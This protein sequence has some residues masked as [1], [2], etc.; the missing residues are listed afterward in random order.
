MRITMKQLTAKP[1]LLKQANLCLIRKVIKNK[2]TATRAEIASETKISSTTVRSLLNE[3]IEHGEIESI[4]HD[5]SSGGRKA[6]RYAFLPNRYY[7]AAFCISGC[8]IHALLVNIC[9]EIVEITQLETIN[10]D[11]EQVIL[12]FLDKLTAKMEIRAIG[13]GVPGIVEGGGYWKQDPESGVLYKAD[14]GTEISKRYG[15]PVI[16]ENNLNATT[17]G[18][19]QCYAKEFPDKEPENMNMAYVHFEKGCICAGFLVG[20]RIVRGCNNFAGELGLVPTE[21]EELLDLRMTKQMNDTQYAKIV[22]HVL[23]WICGIFNPE[24]IVLE[25]PALR[26]DCV[27]SIGNLLSSLLPK[28]MDAEIL[29]SSD[30]WHDYHNGM[31]FLTAGKIFDDVQFIKE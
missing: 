14:I 28:R 30:V 26:K 4:G 2:G 23:C 19:G 12:P 7:S 13:L 24:Y 3:M 22:T 9:G 15:L 27:S 6:E 10:E 21:N 5:E 8:Q 16:L 11:Y 18:F 31:A 17:L 1:K 25:G 29:Y 20:G